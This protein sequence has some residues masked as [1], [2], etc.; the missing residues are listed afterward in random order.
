MTA[1]TWR[2]DVFGWWPQV[3]V[4]GWLMF[5]FWAQALHNLQEGGIISWFTSKVKQ[6]SGPI[7]T[8]ESGNSSLVKMV[9]APQDHRLLM[10][11]SENEVQVLMP[12]VKSLKVQRLRL[13]RPWKRRL[14][15]WVLTAFRDTCRLSYLITLMWYC[16]VGLP[17]R[18]GRVESKKLNIQVN[19]A[20]LLMLEEMEAQTSTATKQAI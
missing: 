17:H 15:F 3:E 11:Q 14:R 10:R 1:E 18:G 16:T 4:R 5:L 8:L 20:R 13:D 2:G 7:C 9:K 6:L 19:A 12:D